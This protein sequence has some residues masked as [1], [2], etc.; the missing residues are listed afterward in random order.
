MVTLRHIADRA[1]VSIETVSRVL[2]GEYKGVR[3]GSARR[4]EQIRA[5][6]EEL[7]YR[8]NAAA[9]A[10]AQSRTK[11]I[12]VVIG[13]DPVSGLTHVAGWE[14]V[15]GVNAA[16]TPSGYV[17]NLVPL[18][19]TSTMVQV[20]SAALRQRMLDAVVVVD[21]AP[22]GIVEFCKSAK[23]PA[24][25][26]NTNYFGK[27][28]CISRD[29]NL[30]GQRAVEAAVG[31]GAKGI[32][33]V[34]REHEWHFSFTD[35]LAGATQAAREAGVGLEVRRFFL[36]RDSPVPAH[37]LADIPAH[38]TMVVADVYL[39]RRLHTEMARLGI[40][41]GVD[42]SVICCDESDDINE[43]WPSLTRVM[44]PRAQ[45]GRRAG[46]MVLALLEGTSKR[47]PSARLA[48]EVYP[49]KTLIDTTTGKTSGAHT[50]RGPR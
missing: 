25:F 14:F 8:P 1:G 21:F 48:C 41:P 15:A 38:H 45:Y 6:A 44:F 34:A 35:R 37:I 20:D 42:L 46:E 31:A 22:T 13:V 28:C 4:M 49:G 26:L 32:V 17:M 33:Y 12:G 11:Q 18:D 3:A 7:N 9:R 43:T 36:H 5:I 19:H 40:R 47:P 50:E 23:L 29:E 39:L 16:I 2:N 24:V 30:A 10:M 27:W